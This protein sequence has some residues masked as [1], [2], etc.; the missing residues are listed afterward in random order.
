MRKITQLHISKI[1]VFAICED[2]TLWRAKIWNEGKPIW[3]K[4]DGPPE[5]DGREP[6]SLEEQAEQL[7]EGGGR[8]L[9]VGRGKKE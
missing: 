8:K 7:A 4:M 1:Y 9:I 5:G 6:P 3:L 2:G